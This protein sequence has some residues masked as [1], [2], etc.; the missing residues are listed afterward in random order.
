MTIRYQDYLNATPGRLD[1]SRGQEPIS[2]QRWSTLPQW[3]KKEIMIW[4]R[5]GPREHAWEGAGGSLARYEIYAITVKTYSCL[6]DGTALPLA[7]SN[8]LYYHDYYPHSFRPPAFHPLPLLPLSQEY[9][10]DAFNQAVSALANLVLWQERRGLVSEPTTAEWKRLF[11]RARDVWARGWEGLPVE[12]RRQLSRS[13]WNAFVRVL[14]GEPAPPAH[15]YTGGKVTPPARGG[16]HPFFFPQVSEQV[17][18]SAED[19]TQAFVHAID[20]IKDSLLQRLLAFDRREEAASREFVHGFIGQCRSH[21]LRYGGRL[22]PIPDDRRRILNEFGV[23]LQRVPDWHVKMASPAQLFECLTITPTLPC[24]RPLPLP[25][26]RASPSLPHISL[27]HASS[28]SRDV[29]MHSLAHG[30]PLRAPDASIGLR[31][32]QRM[33]T[34]QEG[35]AARAARRVY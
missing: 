15:E 29:E 35:W 26:S 30:R 19:S 5:E 9:S 21:L 1:A 4:M 14:A 31:T 12:V 25:L 23:F 2:A 33:G 18:S 13:V 6:D 8:A 24:P 20:L 32:A 11:G 17:A 22:P 7:S 16:A 10:L 34:T 3:V 28:P 27:S